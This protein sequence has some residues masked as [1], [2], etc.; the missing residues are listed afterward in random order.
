MARFCLALLA[1]LLLACTAAPAAEPTAEELRTRSADAMARL[2][3]FS[4][5]LEVLNGAMPLGGGLAATSIDGAVAAP[6]RMQMTVKARA[7]NMPLELRVVGIGERQYM[8]NPLT[9]Q[10]QDAAGALALPRLLDPE[11]GLASTLRGATALEKRG[12]Q[13]QGGVDSFHLAGPVPAE[14]LA[15]LVGAAQPAPGAV[16][17]ELWVAAADYRLHRVRLVGAIVV[18][19][20]PGLERVLTLSDFDAPPRIEAPP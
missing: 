12:R 17:T 9:G 16:Q 4:F 20:P 2:S 14:Q 8:T 11:Q 1:L 18:D 15:R 7:A 6:D 3:G 5:K 10:W 13:S 19:E